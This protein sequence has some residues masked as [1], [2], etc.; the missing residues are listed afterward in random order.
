MK[1]ET[2][3][4]PLFRLFWK[5]FRLEEN[6]T[7][8]MRV[9]VCGYK[10]ICP[11]RNFSRSFRV[12]WAKPNRSFRYPK[13]TVTKQKNGT[14]FPTKSNRPLFIPPTLCGQREEIT[15]VKSS[16][17]NFI[18]VSVVSFL[19][20]N[21]K[22]KFNLKK[23]IMKIQWNCHAKPRIAIFWG[24][25]IWKKKRSK[26]PDGAK[27]G[28]ICNSERGLVLISRSQW[29]EAE[30]KGNHRECRPMMNGNEVGWSCGINQA[31]RAQKKEYCGYHRKCSSWPHVG[32][33][34]KI[35]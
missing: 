4:T 20:K 34:H 17:Y 11:G 32:N 24:Y 7:F 6:N 25:F 3:Y 35:Q 23:K 18:S 19:K 22:G 14:Q 16:A 8:L 5:Y 10:Y 12:H 31:H 21:L 15:T 13:T 27:V 1:S 26:G 29:G 30:E 9:C 2:L 33:K 28:G